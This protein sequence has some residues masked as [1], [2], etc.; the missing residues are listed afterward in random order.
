MG[1]GVELEDPHRVLVRQA[2]DGGIIEAGHARERKLG[3]FGPVAVGVRVVA[4]PG[5]EFGPRTLGDFGCDLIVDEA[6][7][8]SAP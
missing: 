6:G 3:R 5:H 2:V 7:D 8:D 1:E 4:L